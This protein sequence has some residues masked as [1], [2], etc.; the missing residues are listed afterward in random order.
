MTTVHAIATPAQSGTHKIAD[1]N[2]DRRLIHRAYLQAHNGPTV[3]RLLAIDPKGEADPILVHGDRRI[4]GN[5]TIEV[6]LGGEVPAN[7][8]LA[9]QV[10]ASIVIGGSVALSPA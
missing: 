2:E 6:T 10:D 8:D 5:E 4:N 9:L 1:A 7:H 3:V